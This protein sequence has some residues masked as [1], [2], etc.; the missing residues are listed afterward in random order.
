MELM[1]SR[2]EMAKT[3]VMDVMELIALISPITGKN[4]PGIKLL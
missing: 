3:D 2:G 1:A 4:V